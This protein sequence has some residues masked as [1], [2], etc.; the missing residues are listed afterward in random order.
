MKKYFM[1]IVKTLVVFG[2]IVAVCYIWQ[3]MPWYTS[4]DETLDFI[5]CILGAAGIITAAEAIVNKIKAI[6]RKWKLVIRIER[7]EELMEEK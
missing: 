7:K 5:V 4:T 2:A 6:D 1:S 3:E